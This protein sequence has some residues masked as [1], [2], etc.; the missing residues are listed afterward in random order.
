MKPPEDGQDGQPLFCS[1]LLKSKRLLQ[2]NGDLK[3]WPKGWGLDV[4]KPSFVIDRKGLAQIISFRA[5]RLGNAS[6]KPSLSGWFTRR[7]SGGIVLCACLSRVC[8]RLARRLR[9]AIEPCMVLAMTYEADFLLRHVN[10]LE[11]IAI[12]SDVR[13]VRMGFQLRSW[14]KRLGSYIEAVHSVD[15]VFLSTPGQVDLV[16]G[17]EDLRYHL[18]EFDILILFDLAM[19]ATESVFGRLSGERLRRLIREVA[20]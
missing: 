20:G 16:V 2:E 4:I 10:R 5:F 9:T 15:L 14:T 13:E 18:D 8:T 19:V 12:H 6:F 17:W 3:S 7:V 11:V 1:R